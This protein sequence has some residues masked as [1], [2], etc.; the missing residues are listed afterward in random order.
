MAALSAGED[1]SDGDL[2]WEVAAEEAEREGWSS[3]VMR[4]TA[5]LGNEL[6]PERGGWGEVRRKGQADA[7]VIPPR[8]PVCSAPFF[9]TIISGEMRMSL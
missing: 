1:S 5:E 6:H 4:H 9:C 8:L 2:N 3:A 7:Q